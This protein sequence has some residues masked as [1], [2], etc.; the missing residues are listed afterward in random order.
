[1]VEHD[2]T[3]PF[4]I[5]KNASWGG[6]YRVPGMICWPRVIKP[7]T[8][9]TTSCPMKTDYFLTVLIGIALG[10]VFNQK[11][12]CLNFRQQWKERILP[13]RNGSTLM[14]VNETRS[15]GFHGLS[16][17]DEILRK[18]ANDAAAWA[19]YIGYEEERNRYD[20]RQ[21]Y[22]HNCTRKALAI[23]DEKVAEDCDQPH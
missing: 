18:H 16:R 17:R 7:G 4:H 11:R 1:M 15:L 3:T 13:L 12:I 19:V 20:H 5:E 6:G 14:R 22:Q 10:C 21:D 9:S 8:T 2:G 23:P